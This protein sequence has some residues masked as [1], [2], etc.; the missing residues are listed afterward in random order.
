MTM[1][2]RWGC[3]QQLIVTAAWETWEDSQQNTQMTQRWGGWAPGLVAPSVGWQLYVRYITYFSPCIGQS[4][5]ISVLPT[6]R[7]CEGCHSEH[8]PAHSSLTSS[9]R[10]ISFGQTPQSGVGGC[11]M[12]IFLW[13]L[14]PLQLFSKAPC[15]DLRPG[16][17]FL[18]QR[19]LASHLGV[20]L[21]TVASPRPESA[22]L[23]PLLCPFAS[24]PALSLSPNQSGVSGS[25]PGKV[26][27]SRCGRPAFWGSPRRAR[28]VFSP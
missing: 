8:G 21:P 19:L 20:Y 17:G 25:S 6:F 1:G 7:Y 23:A 4:V 26:C 3:H 27:H 12:T 15:S 28:E 16:L 11:M 9:F 24:S 10:F 13:V 14:H 18:P 22:P 2:L 5:D